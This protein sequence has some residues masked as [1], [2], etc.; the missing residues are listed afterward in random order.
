VTNE[1]KPPDATS[2]HIAPSALN[3]GLE[4]IDPDFVRDIELSLMAMIDFATTCHNQRVDRP[5]TYTDKVMLGINSRTISQ[6]EELLRRISD[7]FDSLPSNVEL[8]P[9]SPLLAKVA[10]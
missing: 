4:L 9:T 5:M 1:Q 7:W 6:A 3:V 10:P 8:R 2:E